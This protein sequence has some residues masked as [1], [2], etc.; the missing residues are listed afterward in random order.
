MLHGCSLVSFSAATTVLSSWCNSCFLLCLFQCQNVNFAAALA[1]E[2]FPSAVLMQSEIYLCMIEEAVVAIDHLQ[3]VIL[4]K[5]AADVIFQKNHW[6]K[7]VHES[8]VGTN[9]VGS[10]KLFTFCINYG[11]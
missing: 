11:T 10:K 8:K 6:C 4:S 1:V 5:A 3:S 9:V 7:P 2:G